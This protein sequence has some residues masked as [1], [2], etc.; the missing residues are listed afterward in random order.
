M[1]EAREYG[2]VGG[3]QRSPKAQKEGGWAAFLGPGIHGITTH[4]PR[5]ILW[6][7][8]RLDIYGCARLPCAQVR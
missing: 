2:Y 1:S 3:K 6:E 7:W 4:T 8:C 5:G